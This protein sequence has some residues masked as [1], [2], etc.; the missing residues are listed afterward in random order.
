MPFISYLVSL[1]LIPSFL[2]SLT[3]NQKRKLLLYDK[4]VTALSQEM[5]KKKAQK[6]ILDRRIKPLS[7]LILLNIDQPSQKRYFSSSLQKKALRKGIRFLK[8]YKRTFNKVEKL[9]SIDKEIIL[10]ILYIET[11][12]NP[13][14][15][16][17]NVFNA[18][19]SLAFADHPYF[20]NLNLKRIKRK[21]GNQVP[22]RLTRDE[23]IRRSQRKSEWAIKQL[24]ALVKLSKKMKRPI[25]RIK[26]SFAGAI[27]YPQFIPTSYVSYAVDGNGDR[28]IDLYNIHDSIAS[29]GNYL[30]SVGYE[31]TDGQSIKD[32]IHHYNRS[33]DY[34]DFVISYAKLVK[35]M[36]KPKPKK[37]RRKRRKSKKK[38]VARNR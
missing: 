2:F 11:N 17:Y 37:K 3:D 9:Y 30:K 10:A 6:L 27:G 14:K 23:V 32:A 7:K 24:V 26:G 5:S 13:R 16:R 15:A 29:I 1:L 4:V 8:R 18:Y 34:V 33:W 20:L 38:R 35:K 36:N 25:L 28:F 19:A 22:P 21:Y 31:K 12:F